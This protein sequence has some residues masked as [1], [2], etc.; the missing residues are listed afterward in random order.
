MNT[1]S[2][3]GGDAMPDPVAESAARAAKRNQETLRRLEVGQFF[4]LG[5]KAANSGA[6]R[7]ARLA[8]ALALLPIEDSDLVLATLDE[9]ASPM[10]ARELEKALMG[11]K[12]N[13]TQ[14]KT[15]V[16]ALRG[17]QILMVRQS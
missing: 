11:T 4:R 15:L 17:A 3:A 5:A 6:G 14:R 9:I 12:L 1:E 7:E 13:F 8:S 16:A 10:T 2:M